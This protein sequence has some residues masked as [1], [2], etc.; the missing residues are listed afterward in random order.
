MLAFLIYNPDTGL[1]LF[2]GTGLFIPSV[3]G[4]AGIEITHDEHDAITAPTRMRV[5]D[6]KAVPLADDGQLA[7]AKADRW[8]AI[9]AAR[10]AAEQV[11]F[12]WRG[13]T[14]DGD[15]RSRARLLAAAQI[16]TGATWTLAND[17]RVALNGSELASIVRQRAEEIDVIH[18]RAAALRKQIEGATSLEQVA[19]VV[20]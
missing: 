3:T 18:E 1:G 8:I 2:K 17:S 11:P 13:M 16:G 9:K 4:H 10:D 14:F 20:W 6:G 15:E 12:T 19:A 7:H 5:V